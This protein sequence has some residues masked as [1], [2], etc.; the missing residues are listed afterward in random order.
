MPGG[1]PAEVAPIAAQVVAAEQHAP[2][3]AHFR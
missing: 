2:L 3:V 1:W